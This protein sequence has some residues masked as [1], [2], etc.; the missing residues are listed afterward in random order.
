MVSVSKL[1]SPRTVRLD[2][3]AAAGTSDTESNSGRDTEVSVLLSSCFF[4]K[5]HGKFINLFLGIIRMFFTLK[6]KWK[7]GVCQVPLQRHYGLLHQ[8]GLENFKTSVFR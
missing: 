3:S 1:D 7:E 8:N 6:Q 5:C 4:R 2:Q